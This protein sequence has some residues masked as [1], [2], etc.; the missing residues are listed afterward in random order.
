MALI[1]QQIQPNTRKIPTRDL[2]KRA[3]GAL[4]ALKPVWMISPQVLPQFLGKH[5]E[6]FDILIIDDPP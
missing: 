4:K 3:H 1:K 2:V 6:L 5:R